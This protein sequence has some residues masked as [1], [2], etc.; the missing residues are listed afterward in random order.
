MG[1]GG[2]GREQSEAYE[3]SLADALNLFRKHRGDV[4]AVAEA[5]G[6]DRKTIRNYRAV[7][8]GRGHDIPE[9]VYKQSRASGVE[10]RL[11]LAVQKLQKGAAHL[12]DNDF[13]YAASHHMV[14]PC[15]LP[16]EVIEHVLQR[17]ECRESGTR[18]YRLSEVLRACE[19]F[20]EPSTATEQERDIACLSFL[21]QTS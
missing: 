1:V 11:P 10:K 2:M 13:I 20:L 17:L 14:E 7:L 12:L 6:R 21:S 5:M 19:S 8:R 3:A 4:R 16:R 9:Y 18:G 15:R